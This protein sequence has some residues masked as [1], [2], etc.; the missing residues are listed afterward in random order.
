MSG[1]TQNHFSFFVSLSLCIIL[2]L[3]AQVDAAESISLPYHQTIEFK[4]YPIEY[5]LNQIDPPLNIEYRVTPLFESGQKIECH[6][7]DCTKFD[8]VSYER[9]N[10]NSWFL[11]SVA[12]SQTSQILAEDGFGNNYD[13]I[14]EKKIVIRK[15][16]PYKITVSGTYATVTIDIMSNDPNLNNNV[17]Q[18]V[19]DNSPQLI[20][21]TFVT[22]EKL[23]PS[24]TITIL[25]TSTEPPSASVPILD[26][27]YLTY[28]VLFVFA[29]L[30][31]VLLYDMH[32]KK[33]KPE[34]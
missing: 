3:S 9:I 15:N 8:L 12:N 5:N 34:K 31:A 22:Q 16:G 32:Y 20:A 25:Q 6:N 17:I 4:G 27:N 28:L 26:R 2:C 30:F 14:P 19:K 7:T 29:I 1:I 13:L 23:F 24:P 33:G 18:P 21:S 11:I 10:R